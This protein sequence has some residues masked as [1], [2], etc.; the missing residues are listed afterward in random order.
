MCI[1]IY[2]YIYEVRLR[3]AAGWVGA[4]LTQGSLIRLKKK[5]HRSMFCHVVL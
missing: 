5:Q 1:Y 3:K 2:I 4:I